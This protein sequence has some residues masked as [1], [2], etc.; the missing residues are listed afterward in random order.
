MLEAMTGYSPVLKSVAMFETKY[1]GTGD[2]LSNDS[3]TLS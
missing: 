2:G 3:E 1:I